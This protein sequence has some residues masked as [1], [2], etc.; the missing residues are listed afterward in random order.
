M[1]SGFWCGR[2]PA[3]FPANRSSLRGN[4]D[5]DGLRCLWRALPKHADACR[6]APDPLGCG[7]E[8][9]VQEH[10]AWRDNLTLVVRISGRY[11]SIR[12]LTLVARDPFKKTPQ[13]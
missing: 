10:W 9:E 5:R 1:S 2:A 11:F 7:Q 6:W 3:A 8:V 4:T 13:T 12:P